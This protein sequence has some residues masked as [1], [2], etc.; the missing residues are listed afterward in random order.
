MT[1]RVLTHKK[2][3]KK[4]IAFDDRE[5]E[6]ENPIKRYGH[7][8]IVKQMILNGVTEEEI[9]GEKGSYCFKQ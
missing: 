7:A 3:N 8:I 5:F 9:T 2:T 4:L 6:M 1:Q